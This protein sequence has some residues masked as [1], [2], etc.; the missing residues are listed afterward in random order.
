MIIFVS[1][2]VQTQGNSLFMTCRYKATIL[3]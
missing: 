1:T 2:L 3:L